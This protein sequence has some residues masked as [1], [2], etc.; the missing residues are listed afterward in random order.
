MD[1]NLLK[2]E[3]KEEADWGGLL[4]GFSPHLNFT[5]NS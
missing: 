5:T 3:V 4:E 1:I 2:E